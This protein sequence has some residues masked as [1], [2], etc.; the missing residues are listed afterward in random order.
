MTFNYRPME[1]DVLFVGKGGSGKSFY[2]KHMILEHCDYP[3]WLWDHRHQYTD[4]A[5]RGFAVSHDLRELPYGRAVYQP[6]NLSTDHFDEFC[7]KADTWSNLVVAVEETHLFVGKY[8][9][10]P[11]FGSIVRSGRPKGVTWIVVT[12]RPQDCHNSILGDAEHIFCFEMEL[13]NDIDFMKKWVGKEI[14]LFRDSQ[15]RQ[16]PMMRNGSPRLPPHSFVHKDINT[17][18][19]EIGKI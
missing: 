7:A 12:R 16:D 17:G 15:D 14:E 18:E 2:L 8:K 11:H 1:D 3:L 13:P 9:M 4:L 5:Q 19:V 10:P 6:F